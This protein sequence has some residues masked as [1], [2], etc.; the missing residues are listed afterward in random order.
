MVSVS[1]L[2]PLPLYGSG[3]RTA[4]ISAATWPTFCLSNPLIWI[5]VGFSH[6]IVML[7]GIG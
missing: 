7:Y 2:M 1:Y 3:G 6:L 4:R 5:E